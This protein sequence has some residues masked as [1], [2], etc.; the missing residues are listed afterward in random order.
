MSNQQR[1]EQ[2]AREDM[3]LFINACFACS[4]Q[5]EYYGETSGQAVAISFLHEYILG[6]YRRLYAR[7]LAAGINHFNQGLMITNLLACEAPT[8]PELKREEGALLRAALRSLP[9]R[10]RIARWWRCASSGSTT[11][12]RGRSP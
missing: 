5:S 11:G 3:V 8:D 2:V 1:M 4:G 9:R 10:G 6:N 7:T 12:G